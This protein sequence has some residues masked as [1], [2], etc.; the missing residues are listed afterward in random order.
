MGQPKI[1]RHNTGPLTPL[2]DRPPREGSR[3]AVLTIIRNRGSTM[4]TYP[5]RFD[6]YDVIEQDSML[7]NEIRLIVQATYLKALLSIIIG[8]GFRLVRT[9][10]SILEFPNIYNCIGFRRTND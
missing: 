8:G 3:A 10:T 5:I 6:W 7:R 4:M 9:K 2:Q 1:E